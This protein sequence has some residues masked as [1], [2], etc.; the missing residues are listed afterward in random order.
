M[1][2]P[3]DTSSAI[4]LGG[5][6]KLVLEARTRILPEAQRVRID[7]RG[8]FVAS[9]MIAGEAIMGIV[10]AA[11]FLGGIS[12]FTRVL[13]GSDALSFYPASGGWLSIVA[14]AAIAYGLLRVPLRR[15]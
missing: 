1:Y 10:L 15:A 6:I 11:T 8:S 4:A 3:F 7:D 2:R 14:F 9:G 12:S 13:T 5:L